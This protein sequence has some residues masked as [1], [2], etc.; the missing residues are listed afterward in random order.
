[1]TGDGV[2]DT[3]AITSADVG[4][5]MGT[6]TDVAKEAADM[7]ITDDSFNSI[8]AGI[9]EGR[10]IFEKI[11]SIIFFYIA[12]DVAEGLLFYGASF[13]PNLYLLNGWQR[14]YTLITAHS[15]PPF[16]LIIDRLSKDVMREKPRD[17]ESFSKQQKI[18][19]LFFSTSLAFIFYVVY[20]GTL[21]GSIP[22]F[23]QNKIGFIPNFG[24]YDTY[25]PVNWAQAKARTMLLT[26]M[27]VAEST[28]VISIR[29]VNK[30]FHRIL[31][32]DNYWMIWPF[33][34][35]P[36]LLHVALMYLPAVQ[37]MLVR[38]VGINL[39]IIQLT[40]IDWTIAIILGLIPIVLL[41]SVKRLLRKQGPLF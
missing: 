15:L 13:I 23:W 29:R 14:I 27:L 26:V 16:G 11:R 33:I 19:F 20:F 8:V 41:E 1:M 36:P 34:L 25:S 37:L 40:W 5:S 38:S 10:G 21:N 17:R 39:E 24:L 9:R 18:A 12:V 35:A 32:E 31:I 6:G 3:L 7:I 30:P 28:L 4:I 2:N 22:L